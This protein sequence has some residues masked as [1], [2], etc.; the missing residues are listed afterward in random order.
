MALGLLGVMAALAIFIS[1]VL[2]IALFYQNGRFVE[3]RSIFTLIQ[4]YLIM[5]AALQITAVATNDYLGQALGWGI[6]LLTVATF[7]IRRKN[8]LAARILLA[9]LLVAA[10]FILYWS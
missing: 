1:A 2:I 4:A 8:F 7:I 5:L 6:V 3:N 10:P 9:V